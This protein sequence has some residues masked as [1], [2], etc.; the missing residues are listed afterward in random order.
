M[1]ENKI[2]RA[3]LC[4]GP[5]RRRWRANQRRVLSVLRTRDLDAPVL[6]LL[7]PILRLGEDDLG[8]FDGPVL[9]DERDAH[10][11]SSVRLEHPAEIPESQQLVV[12]T[13]TGSSTASS[14]S[15]WHRSTSPRGTH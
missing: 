8:A 15:M 13:W 5:D 1:Y 10:P 4:A 14:S 12:H 9:Q 7:R 6:P 3:Q 2:R 11:P